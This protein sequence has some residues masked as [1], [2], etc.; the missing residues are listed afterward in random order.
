MELILVG[1]LTFYFYE[2]TAGETVR[3]FANPQ[4]NPVLIPELGLIS[5]LSLLHSQQSI[6]PLGGGKFSNLAQGIND[7]NEENFITFYLF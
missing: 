6:F 5:E 7:D 1:V 3:D 4:Y 2:S